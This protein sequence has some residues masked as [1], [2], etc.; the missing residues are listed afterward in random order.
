MKF[1]SIRNTAVAATALVACIGISTASFAGDKDENTLT[2]QDSMVKTIIDKSVLNGEILKYTEADAD[3]DKIPVGFAV[4]DMV[5]DLGPNGEL[6]TDPSDPDTVMK[7][8]LNDDRLLFKYT[9]DIFA[10]ETNKNTGDLEK[11]TNKIGT[12][13]GTAA[14]PVSFAYL[15]GGFKVIMGLL[16]SGVEL[17]DAMAAVMGPDPKLPPVL[18]WTC[19]HCKMTIGDNTYVNIVDALTPGNDFYMPPLAGKFDVMLMGGAAGGMDSMRLSAKA[20]LGLTPA[21]MD[22]NEETMSIRM[23]GCSAIVAAAGP[24][25]PQ[26]DGEGNMIAPPMMGTLCLN[27]TATFD[28]TDT[29]P[30][31]PI[32][33]GSG[34]SGSG[35]SNCVTMLHR[36]TM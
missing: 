10:V 36:P 11:I 5:I 30:M 15:S 1:G 27:S 32:T 25:G 17:P 4:G 2:P 12:I 7:N 3:A 33:G 23:G 8:P 22:L 20:Y 29:D 9:G 18:E 34:I 16:L 21:S 28:V 13:E 24:D 26:F 35:S 31:A 14:F 6:D 19:N